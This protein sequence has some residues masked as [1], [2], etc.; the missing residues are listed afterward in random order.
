MNLIND[1]EPRRSRRLGDDDPLSE[2]RERTIQVGEM[3]QAVIGNDEETKREG[4]ASQDE[5]REEV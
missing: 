3:Y 2:H 5:E 4:D 1:F